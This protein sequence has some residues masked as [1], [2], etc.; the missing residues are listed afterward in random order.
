MPL[1][2]EILQPLIQND[3]AAPTSVQFLAMLKN[4]PP[5]GRMSLAL[6]YRKNLRLLSIKIGADCYVR[7]SQ[8]SIVCCQVVSQ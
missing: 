7:V 5:H 6:P 4:E 8:Q 2:R 3:I 1:I